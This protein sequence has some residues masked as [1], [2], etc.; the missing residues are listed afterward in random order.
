MR[1]A[2]DFKSGG[3]EFKSVLITCW[4]CFPRLKP[5]SHT[6]ASNMKAI[7][8]PSTS[9]QLFQNFELFGFSLLFFVLPIFFLPLS[10]AFLLAFQCPF[11]SSKKVSA[12][13]SRKVNFL[14]E[15]CQ[16]W[17]RS[18]FLPFS[19][20]KFEGLLPLSLAQSFP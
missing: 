2:A 20:H 10:S 12:L 4:R 14:E 3:R 9:R 11:Y 6:S 17:G 16:W 19:Q 5:N 7:A 13:T 8:F 15:K 18:I 1:R